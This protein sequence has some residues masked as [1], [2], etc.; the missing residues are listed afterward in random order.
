MPKKE[1]IMDAKA[2]AK[3]SRDSQTRKHFVLWEGGV[4]FG[5]LATLINAGVELIRNHEQY[6]PLS[7]PTAR[8]YFH[9]FWLV[10]IT[11]AIW[12]AC[13]CLF[14]LLMWELVIKHRKNLKAE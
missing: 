4:M 10:I 13:G 7:P 14:G 5:G 12:F 9:W 2:Q 1:R 11:P 6:V 8:V 3:G